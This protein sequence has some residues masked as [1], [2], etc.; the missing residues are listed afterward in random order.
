VFLKYLG[1]G[2]SLLGLCAAVALFW[3]SL[4]GASSKGTLANPFFPHSYST[5]DIILSRVSMKPSEV[6]VPSLNQLVFLV[7]TN[8]PMVKS[9][10]FIAPNGRGA[11]RELCTC[12][13]TTV[14]QWIL[15]QLV[16]KGK[17]V[18]NKSRYP[19]LRVKG[20]TRYTTQILLFYFSTAKRDF[21]L[22]R[23]N[24]IIRHTK[25]HLNQFS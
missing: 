2:F 4:P 13:T 7:F 6:Q 19:A 10:I 16:G 1:G 11:K 24:Y 15:H 8:W 3:C 23:F 12:S 18:N 20:P 17:T 9:R 14:V 5:Y 22:I 21:R 25:S